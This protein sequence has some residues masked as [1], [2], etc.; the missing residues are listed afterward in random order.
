M[1][2]RY[3]IINGELYHYGVKGMKWG[4]RKARQLSSA[5]NRR[6][7]EYYTRKGDRLTAEANAK[8]NATMNSTNR[9]IKYA[10]KEQRYASAER[11]HNQKALGLSY[12]SK[13]FGTTLDY[14]YN[15]GL[16]ERDA[17]L[18]EKYSA[19]KT[20]TTNKVNRLEY[21]ADKAYAKAN[22]AE[23]KK[24]VA[25]SRLEGK[26]KEEVDRMLNDRLGQTIM[27]ETVTT[28]NPMIN[29]KTAKT[30][31]GYRGYVRI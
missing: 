17:I 12:I 5:I 22:K 3:T 31:Y 19:A 28:R 2:T 4:V 10:A 8:R 18:K 26:G 7:S 13:L 21:R 30:K 15:K 16:A 20:G 1:E 9:R 14:K 11:F 29:D 27:S 24:F 6:K 25:D 23:N